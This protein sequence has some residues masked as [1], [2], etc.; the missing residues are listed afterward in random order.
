MRLKVGPKKA[1]MEAINSVENLTYRIV[2]LRLDGEKSCVE[3]DKGNL[4][5]LDEYNSKKLLGYVCAFQR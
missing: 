2:R 1:W 4:A 3:E 5:D